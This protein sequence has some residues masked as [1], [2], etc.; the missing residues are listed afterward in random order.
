MVEGVGLGWSVF[1][2]RFAETTFVSLIGGN[3]FLRQIGA[4]LCGKSGN[5]G[6]GYC[7]SQRGW[8]VESAHGNFLAAGESKNRRVQTVIVSPA[9]VIFGSSEEFV[10][11]GTSG[12][13]IVHLLLEG[14]LEIFHS[15]G[16]AGVDLMEPPNEL[17]LVQ[18]VVVAVMRLADENDAFGSKLGGQLI[19]LESRIQIDRGDSTSLPVQPPKKR[20][21]RI[22][23]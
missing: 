22:R 8:H 19:H 6:L 23:A 15:D 3:D 11:R 13:V 20:R 2:E 5:A 17:Q 14:L 18:M 4:L 7:R 12:D 9:L 10:F 21:Q 1:L 16:Q